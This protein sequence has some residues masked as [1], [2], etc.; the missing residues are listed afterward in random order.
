MAKD[1]VRMPSSGAGLTTFYEESKSRL[2][3]PPQTILFIAILVVIITIVLN[4]L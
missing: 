3:I 4:N 2:H 1:N